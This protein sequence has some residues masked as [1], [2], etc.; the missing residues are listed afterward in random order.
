MGIDIKKDTCSCSE[1]ESNCD[2]SCTGC[3]CTITIGGNTSKV[4]KT[5]F[6]EFLRHLCN[7]S[8]ILFM[9]AL[10]FSDSTFLIVALF[11]AAIVFEEFD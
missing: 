10:I 4:G 6:Q 9:V 8:W 2:C 5:A 11:V 3:K 7:I 1:N